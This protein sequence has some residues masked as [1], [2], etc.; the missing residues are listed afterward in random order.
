ME[1][2]SKIRTIINAFTNKL[3]KGEEWYKERLEI[4]KTCSYN[5]ANKKGVSLK[6]LIG[7]SCTAC[8]C[9]IE[10]K[11]AMKEE[12]CGLSQIGMTPKWNKLSIIT[13][14]SEDYNLHN[15]S[16]EKVNISL[17]NNEYILDYGE[18]YKTSDT[19]VEVLLEGTS[20]VKETM[21]SCGCTKP[22]VTILSASLTKLNIRVDLSKQNGN[23]SKTIRVIFM[24]GRSIIIKLKAI[25]RK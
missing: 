6:D 3:P 10:R 17:E 8:G 14:S 23:M 22:S 16:P 13:N 19:N 11:A 4:C 1:E 21:V 7:A 2:I 5:T 12:E 15:N 20:T 25:I 18:L 9:F 24:D